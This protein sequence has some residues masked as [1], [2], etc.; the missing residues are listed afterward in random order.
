[1]KI[2][3]PARKDI[4]LPVIWSSAAVEDQY[5]KHLER[6][7][8]EMANSVLYWMSAEWRKNPPVSVIAQDR[9]ATESL[10]ITMNR[11]SRHW[12]KRINDLGDD[13]ARRFA[14]GSLSYYDTAFSSALK[15]AGFTVDF[16]VTRGM[17]E[18]RH[19]VINEN[20]SLIRSI[21]SEYFTEIEGEVWRAISQGYQL[22]TLRENLQQRCGITRQRA[23]FIARDQT[24]KAN[25][26]FQAE[27]MSEIGIDE[28]VWRHSGAGKVPR[29]S[30]QNA[31]NKRFVITRGMYIDGEWILPGQKP[32]CGCSWQAVIKGLHKH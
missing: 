22:D 31:N 25:S 19:T 28:G 23:A 10:R 4:I 8:D 14:D 5:E 18:I 32:N 29:V 1:M 17:N 13:V 26:A 7:V 2:I 21:P 15:K 3:A 12:Q 11:L 16:R 6:L 30:H 24:N 20:V 27:R 9:S